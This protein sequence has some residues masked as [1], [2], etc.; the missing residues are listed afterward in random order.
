[1]RKARLIPTALLAGAGLLL[2]GCP[3]PSSQAQALGQSTA[4]SQ[5]FDAVR[6]LI[7][8]WMEAFAIPS[9]AVGVAHEGEI[10]WEEGFGWA[11]RERNIRATEHT[12]YSVASVTKPITATA[13]ALLQEE[14]KLGLDDPANDLLRSARITVR[15]SGPSRATIREILS[16][17]AGLPLHHH[18]FFEDDEVER[19]PME[20]TIARY[21]VQV[22]EPGAVYNYSNVGYGILDHLIEEASGK[23]YGAFLR[24][25]IFDPLGMERS[26]LGKNPSMGAKVAARYD[27]AGSPLP[28]YDFDH[29]G[30][31]AVYAS[32]HDLLRFG[33]F[34]LGRTPEEAEDIL[35]RSVLKEMQ[36]PHAPSAEGRSYGL[37]WAVVK[38]DNGYVR[39]EHTGGMPGVST[40][41]RLYPEE[42]AVV[43]VLSNS[44]NPATGP[45]A[46]ALAGVV[47]TD[48]LRR[49][50]DGGDAPTGEG[51]SSRQ[52]STV[53]RGEWEG[54][55]K[56]WAGTIPMHLT[57]DG[58]GGGVVRFG[59]EP[60]TELHGLQV[61]DGRMSGQFAGTIPTED[62]LTREHVIHVRL[63]K[64]GD[65]LQGFAAA[66][67]W[68]GRNHFALS[69][70]AL[71][72]R[73]V[74][75]E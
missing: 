10:L 69:S 19:P 55:V 4:G 35:P 74:G 49:M 26:A 56:T 50:G 71:L 44:S 18:F 25:R 43:V 67:A 29:R 63:W 33:L 59:G 20:V 14:G 48:Y 13:I 37:G 5:D 12:A 3:G 45:I 54:E 64:E 8:D 15:G 70:P 39:V 73:N 6:T 31:S 23:D 11:D 75:P 46:D 52:G 27:E 38:D 72:Q 66:L 36:T 22:T 21:G 24:S 58:D 7:E 40:A 16:H 1:M 17:T 2:A 34:H 41:L 30:A 57:L 60:P 65:Q 68:R 51:R 47:L 62:A 42:D 61:L 53:F 9:V 28:D 32:V